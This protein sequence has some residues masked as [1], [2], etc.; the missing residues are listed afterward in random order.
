MSEADDKQIDKIVADAREALEKYSSLLWPKERELYRELLIC[1]DVLHYHLAAAREERDKLHARYDKDL[2]KERTRHK[3]LIKM[4]RSGARALRETW[5]EMDALRA[6]CDA[7]LARLRAVE[8]ERDRMKDLLYNV[9]VRCE[10]EQ[11]TPGEHEHPLYRKSITRK[12]LY[13]WGCRDAYDSIVKI[14]DT[15]FSPAPAKPEREVCESC[16]DKNNKGPCLCEI[17]GNRKRKLP[18]IEREED[19]E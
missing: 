12:E 1:I 14:L 7:A 5:P 18:I 6:E 11:E 9:W 19:G 17:Q 3:D 4:C 2:L 13:E 15:L 10:D 8:E 16:L